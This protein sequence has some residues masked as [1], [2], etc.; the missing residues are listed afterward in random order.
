MRI[1]YFEVHGFRSLSNVKISGLGPVNTFYGENNAGK[2]NILAAFEI[3]FRVDRVEEL[4]SPVAGFLRGEL[5]DFIDN[6]TVNTD[7][8]KAAKIDIK[9]RIGLSDEDLEATPTFSKL[10]KDTGIYE[11][12]HLQ[13]IQL[14]MEIIPTSPYTATRLLKQA[15]VNNKSIYDLSQPEVNRFFPTLRGAPSGRQSPAEEIFRY[16]INC[17]EIIH[18]QRFLQEEE[19]LE[20]RGGEISGKGFKNWLL[21]LS[22][23]REPGYTMFRDII[24]WFDQRPF[25]F[26]DIRPIVE[27]G[28]VNLIVRTNTGQEL[29]IDRL[30]TGVQ[31]ILLL[32]SGVLAKS[33]KLMAIEEMELNLSPSLQNN[34][35]LVL[36]NIVANNAQP[37]DQMFLSSHS[38]HLGNR[39]D[40]VLYAVK[41]NSSGLTEVGRGPSAIANLRP[42]F[43]FGLFRI[44]KNKMWRS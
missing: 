24:K 26:G 31:Q 42:H 30:G 10:I 14:E 16:L 12:G 25:S 40:T 23:S 7:G 9:V 5:S 32:L 33:T 13:R 4:E 18:A 8:T 37:K 17:Y 34:T 38:M 28:K 27:N 44:P 43:D 41:I 21:G 15:S 11:S 3:A 39:H 1:Q 6:F 20:S 2:S 36:K 29:T 22:E 35:L 19:W